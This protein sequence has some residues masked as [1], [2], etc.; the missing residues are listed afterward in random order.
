MNLA[1]LF[2]EKVSVSKIA[3]LREKAGLTQRELALK[4]GVTETTIRNYEKGRSWVAFSFMS[5]Y[6]LCSAMIDSR[7]SAAIYS[8]SAC[9]KR[10]L[11]SLSLSSFKAFS[12]S[13]YKAAIISKSLK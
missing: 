4:V 12:A 8:L 9:A 1:N 5:A 10:R 7:F 2:M 6:S 3:E 11:A 13:S